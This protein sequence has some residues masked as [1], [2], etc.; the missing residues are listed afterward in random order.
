MTEARRARD[1]AAAAT[2]RQALS[3]IDNA[4]AVPGSAEPAGTT[5]VVGVG[6]GEVARREVS[7]D[8]ARRIVDGEIEERRSAAALVEHL[9]PDHAA[10]LRAGAAAL[11]AI[12]AEP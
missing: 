2:F 5:A 6:A 10:E 9:H 3:A 4:G 12:L 11:T 7:E 1:R 8:D